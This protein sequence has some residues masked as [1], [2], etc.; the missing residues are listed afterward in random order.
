MNT[1][2]APT[3]L[4]RAG[5]TRGCQFPQEFDIMQFIKN[6]SCVHSSWTNEVPVCSWDG[7]ACNRDGKISDIDWSERLLKGRFQWLY[8]PSSTLQFYATGNYLSGKLPLGALPQNFQILNIGK[9]AHFGELDFTQLP[10][11]MDTLFLFE[12]FFTGVVDFSKLPSTLRFLNVNE[13]SGLEGVLNLS[14]IGD[15][16]CL[17]IKGTQIR[18]VVP[19]SEQ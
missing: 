5:R 18:I 6:V 17:S 15:D 16:L 3:P 19:D 12:N 8:L 10:P 9:N 14:E 11:L 13:N 2:D 7:V 1:E 4:S